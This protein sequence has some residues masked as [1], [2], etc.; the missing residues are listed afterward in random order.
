M[1]SGL[2][3]NWNK[4]KTFWSK[5][6]CEEQKVLSPVAQRESEPPS[7]PSLQLSAISTRSHVSSSV[8]GKAKFW[9]TFWMQDYEDFGSGYS[10]ETEERLIL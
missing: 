9:K 3:N 5:E 6:Y 2:S 7:G 1:W 8:V 4:T 10:I